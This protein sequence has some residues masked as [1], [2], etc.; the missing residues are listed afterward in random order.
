[1]NHVFLF[2]F[3]TWE[4]WKST[5]LEFLFGCSVGVFAGFLLVIIIDIMRFILL[6]IKN[7]RMRKEDVD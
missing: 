2:I 6:K 1:M 3:K 4:Y 5:M 7:R